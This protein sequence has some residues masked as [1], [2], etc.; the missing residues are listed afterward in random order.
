MDNYDAEIVERMGYLLMMVQENSAATNIQSL[1]R[2]RSIR[3][4]FKEGNYWENKSRAAEMRAKR[5]ATAKASLLL[6][7]MMKGAIARRRVKKMKAERAVELKRKGLRDDTKDKSYEVVFEG[8]G[9]LGFT[10]RACSEDNLEE[11]KKHGLVGGKI[12]MEKPLPEVSTVKEDSRAEKKTIAPGD[13]LLSIN[14]EVIVL[15]KL[16]KKVKKAREGGA[17][18]TFKFMRGL[19][20]RV[21]AH[22]ALA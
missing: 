14:K 20:V 5:D 18:A 22:T 4:Q 13:L 11:A 9:S 8:E 12:S 19:R 2:G 15:K 10:L 1:Y 7:R 3:Q 17:K 16:K 6:R 21:G